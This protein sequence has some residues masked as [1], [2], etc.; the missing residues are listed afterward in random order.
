MGQKPQIKS[1]QQFRITPLLLSNLWRHRT[2][3]NALEEISFVENHSYV[4]FLYPEESKNNFSLH[5]RP[6]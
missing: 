5:F 4:L 2:K 1:T 6:Q 3:M